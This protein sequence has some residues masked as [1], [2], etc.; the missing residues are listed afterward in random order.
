MFLILIF[1]TNYLISSFRF[2]DTFSDSAE[3]KKQKK[4]NE[5]KGQAETR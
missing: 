3:E 2:L 4:N 5:I 1:L